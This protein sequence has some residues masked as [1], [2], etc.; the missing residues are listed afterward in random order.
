MRIVNFKKFIRSV[1]ILFTITLILSL[2]ISKSTLSHTEIKY[3]TIYVSSGDTLWSIAQNLQD[4][5]EYYKNKDIRYIVYDLMEENS[6]SS[7]SL[8]INQELKIPIA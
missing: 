3:K 4:T 8:Y 2:F 7:S 6:L 5:T 1:F